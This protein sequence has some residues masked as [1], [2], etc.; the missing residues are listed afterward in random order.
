MSKSTCKK[1]T[2]QAPIRSAQ[3][4]EKQQVVTL[5]ITNPNAAGIDIGDKMHAV[6]VGPDKDPSPVRKFGTFTC[7]LKAIISWLKQCE[8]T[9]VAMESTGVYWK[10]LCA[11]LLEHGFD[12]W[13]VN[14]KQLK[15][16]SG[17]K[18]DM[19][20]AAWI[21]K[22]HSCGV[23][24]RSF[25]LDD[26]TETVRSIVRQRRALIQDANRCTQR[27]QKNLELMNI[28]IHT[29]I[30]DIMG[31]TGKAILEA[32]L[33]GERKAENF[34]PLID[35]RIKASHEDILKSLKATGA[36]NVYL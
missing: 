12:V 9:S 11:M 20:D 1:E 30:N 8:V 29:V 32:I 14:A 26:L 23:L 5:P 15:N 34:I 33:K 25:L 13:L 22:M 21:Q 27:I 36:V 19:S 18:T 28:K 31:K 16:V 10:P 7:D 2:E 3:A 4:K 17:K 35:G 6:A 24:P